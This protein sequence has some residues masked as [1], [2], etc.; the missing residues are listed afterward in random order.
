MVS[1]MHYFEVIALQTMVCKNFNNFV[2]D[3]GTTYMM[4]PSWKRGETEIHQITKKEGLAIKTLG[5]A[6]SSGMRQYLVQ[7]DTYTFTQMF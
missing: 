2:V 7:A 6:K 3:A 1:A 4:F 5:K